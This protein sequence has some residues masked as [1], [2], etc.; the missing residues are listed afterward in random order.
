V[1]YKEKA[2]NTILVDFEEGVLKVTNNLPDQ[3]NAL[4]LEWMNEFR[5]LLHQLTVDPEVKVLVITGAGSTFCAGGN[6]KEMGREP[7]DRTEAHPLNRPLWNIPTMTVEERISQH[8]T[9][10]QRIFVELANLGKPTIAVINGTAAG[11]GFDMSLACDLRYVAEEAQFISSF[12]RIGI[13]PLDGGLWH[14]S[15]IVG[16]TR[17]YEII[18]TG[19]PVTGR[20]AERIGLAN[21]ALPLAELMPYAMNVAKKLA[22]GPSVSYQLIK[23]FMR[24]SLFMDLPEAFEEFYSVLP[25]MYGTADHKEAV[26]AFLEKREAH[27]QGK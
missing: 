13:I 26:K 12:V 10:G 15:R 19:N 1:D 2:Y 17:A 24:K 20:D 6:I 22:N 7:K 4:T 9:S 18:Y 23:H 5:P 11:A 21:K 3:R 14:L 8:T 16:M 25:V 27:F